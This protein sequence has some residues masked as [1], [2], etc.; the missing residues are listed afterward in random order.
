MAGPVEVVLCAIPTERMPVAA[1]TKQEPR[2]RVLHTGVADFAALLN[3]LPDRNQYWR[4]WQRKHRG[5][6]P[7]AAPDEESMRVC[8]LMVKPYD[9][10]H[11]RNGWPYVGCSDP[12]GCL[13]AVRLR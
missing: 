10:Q 5:W 7:D 4:Q 8:L 12:D 13:Q 3:G 11:V 6:W 2:L 1:E 9:D